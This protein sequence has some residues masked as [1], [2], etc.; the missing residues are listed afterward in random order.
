MNLVRKMGWILMAEA[1]L[2]PP[3]DDR[4]S[5]SHWSVM[6][7]IAWNCR[8]ALNPEFQNHV[9][10]LVQHHNP[11]MLIVMETRVGADRAK[12][13]TDRLPF[14]EAIHTET[15]GYAGGLWLLWK[16]DRVIVKPLATTEQEIHVSVKVRPSDS[17]C[18]F[19]A[20]YA[21]PRFNERCVLWNNLVNVA[22]LHSSPW[23]IAGDFNEVLADDE[24]YGGRVVNANR[25]LLFKDCLDAR[26]MV[27]LGF[28]GPRFTWSNRR[29]F[30]NLIQERLDRFFGNPKWC[31]LY[32]NTRVSHLTRV[33]SDHC[34]I[35]L[36]FEPGA[37]IRLNR[38][39][40]FQSFWLNDL[41]FPNIVRDA[42]GQSNR[43]NTVVEKFT[44][45]ATAWN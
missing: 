23:I 35:L 26:N 10:E 22:S 27:D 31:T 29:G 15:I 43:L 1:R 45:D 36:E 40:K 25:A 14:D 3:F 8:G 2:L 32:P 41:S 44:K 28:S 11:A 20:V 18:I 5:L 42:W 33:H 16:S 34:P 39:F 6:N 38:P 30:R 17:E 4:R 13:I 37:S 12:E 21:S 19:S 24:K 7:I 9:R